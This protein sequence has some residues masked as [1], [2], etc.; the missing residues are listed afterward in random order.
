MLYQRSTHPS[1]SHCLPLR[2]AI[3]KV[4]L[5]LTLTAAFSLPLGCKE[6]GEVGGQG[7]RAAPKPAALGIDAKGRL[8]LSPGDRCPVCG[9]KVTKHKRFASGIALADGT[10]YHF[11]GSGCMLK[12]WIAP[13]AILGKAKGELA[14]AVT[15]EYFGGAYVDA[16]QARWVSGS[17]V[18][19]AMG[20]A[21][22]PLKDDADLKTFRERHGGKVTFRLS[23]LNPSSWPKL[24]GKP[25]LGKRG[26]HGKG[27]HGKGKHGK[28]GHGT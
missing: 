10:T 5:A 6:G 9:M 27:K 26:K 17:D 4:A 18:V 19:G 8:Q 22:V 24:T 15:R 2:A 28:G 11:C 12:A 3:R 13:Q 20:P 7:K 25:A 23:E 21:I 14:R 16:K 1:P